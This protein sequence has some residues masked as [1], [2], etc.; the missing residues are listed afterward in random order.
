VITSIR[1]QT[2]ETL[3]LLSGQCRATLLANRHFLG[4]F[5][6]I[7]MSERVSRLTLPILTSADEDGRAVDNDTIWSVRV[8][9]NLGT[10]RS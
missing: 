6:L 2:S 8:L 7:G 4:P 5:S 10:R 1:A 3:V 9:I